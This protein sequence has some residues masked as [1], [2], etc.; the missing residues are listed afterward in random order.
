MTSDAI[1]SGSTGSSSFTSRGRSTNGSRTLIDE[2]PM[3]PMEMDGESS[4]KVG[5]EVAVTTDE[6]S[7]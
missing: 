4:C 5:V 6:F 3:S 7:M 2:Y 1:T